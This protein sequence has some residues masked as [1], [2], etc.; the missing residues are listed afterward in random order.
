MSAPGI[1]Y[2]DDCNAIITSP[3][4]YR[5]IAEKIPAYRLF[6]LDNT[7]KCAVRSIVSFLSMVY[8]IIMVSEDGD[9]SIRCFKAAKHLRELRQFIRRCIDQVA[10]ENNKVRI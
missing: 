3:N 1:L 8:A 7:C 9:Y 10:G 5:L 4:L 6:R 2:S